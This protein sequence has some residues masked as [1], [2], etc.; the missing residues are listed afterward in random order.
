MPRSGITIANSRRR[1]A[2]RLLLVSPRDR[3]FSLRPPPAIRVTPLRGGLSA[4]S[5]QSPPVVGAAE[6]GMHPQC[7]VTGF[8]RAAPTAQ[9]LANALDAAIVRRYNSLFG[10]VWS[11]RERS[12]CES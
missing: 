7:L 1:A 10:E 5:R 4:D 3:G 2:T 11:M 9:S 8:A 12:P 6:T